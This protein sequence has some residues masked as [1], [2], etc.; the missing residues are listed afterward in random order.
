MEQSGR[1]YSKE[2]LKPVYVHTE[3]IHN[4]NAPREVVPFIMRLVK[5]ISVLDVGCGTG[6]WL[7]AFEENGVT[8][9]VGIDATFLDRS[10][11]RIPENKFLAVDLQQQWS[12]NRKFDL[13]ISLE[14]AEHLPTESADVFVA[15]LVDHAETIVFS[16]AIPGQG[17]QNH[18][19]EQWP[20]YWQEKFLKHGYYFHDVIRPLI[21]NNKSVDWWYK[22]NIFL[23]KQEKPANEIENWILPD[24]LKVQTNLVDEI[25]RGKLGIK[26]SFK[27]FLKSILVSIGLK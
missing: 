4:L 6:T 7:K 16:A 26:S 24:S 27:I 9:Y 23:I 14:V 25:L 2:E 20:D 21:W 11:L 17:G 12:L 8:D 13:A 15:S 19:N 5:P 1:L 10:L 3:L 22:Q 18:I